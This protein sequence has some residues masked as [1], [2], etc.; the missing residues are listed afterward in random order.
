MRVGCGDKARFENAWKRQKGQGKR[1]FAGSVT[2]DIHPIVKAH[3]T[4]G[5]DFEMRRGFH[6]IYGLELLEDS[7]YPGPN[8]GQ[9]L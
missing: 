5:G 2:G 8:L 4:A 1:Y 9:S 6:D 3:M 7:Y